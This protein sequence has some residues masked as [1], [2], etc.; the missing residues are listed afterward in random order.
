M[1]NI[2]LMKIAFTAVAVAA[3]IYAINRFTDG[4]V[5]NFGRPAAK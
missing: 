2:D 3:G 4:G 1:K 5:S